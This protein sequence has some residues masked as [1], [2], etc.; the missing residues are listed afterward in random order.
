M[1]LLIAAGDRNEDIRNAT[2]EVLP[3]PCDDERFREL[4]L[5]VLKDRHE[6]DALRKSAIKIISSA[7]EIAEVK[8]ALLNVLPDENW[9]IKTSTM[10]ALSNATHDENIRN[11][12]VSLS[13]IHI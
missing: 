12:L 4:L 11:A 8:S 2:P 7:I 1:A 6:V 13:L 9:S 5:E 3:N 10:R